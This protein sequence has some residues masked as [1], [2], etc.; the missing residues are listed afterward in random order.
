MFNSIA[1]AII[2]IIV[3]DPPYVRS[4][5]GIPVNGI[6]PRFAAIFTH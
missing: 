4:G 5:A 3:L 2:V 6:I 1:I